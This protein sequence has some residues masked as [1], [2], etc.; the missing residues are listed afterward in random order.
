M[1]YGQVFQ[2]ANTKWWNALKR[3][4]ITFKY[5]FLQFAWLKDKRPDTEIMKSDTYATQLTAG[6]RNDFAL[7]TLNKDREQIHYI[8]VTPAINMVELLF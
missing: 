8:G 5:V 3:D 1:T 7:K 4:R 6:E 2:Y